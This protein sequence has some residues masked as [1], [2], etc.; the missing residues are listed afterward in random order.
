MKLIYEERDLIQ[1][2]LEHELKRLETEEDINIIME[3][4]L[5]YIYLE[6]IQNLKSESNRFKKKYI[7]N[8]WNNINYQSL[9]ITAQ[10]QG[11]ILL[12]FLK[13]EINKRIKMEMN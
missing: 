2:V 7:V 3:Y 1:A 10:K 12:Y 6:I 8:W 5:Y 13:K 9:N 4:K 11:Y